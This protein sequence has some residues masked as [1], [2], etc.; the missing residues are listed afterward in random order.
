[1]K[2]GLNQRGSSVKTKKASSV[3]QDDDEESSLSGDDHPESHKRTTTS[4]RDARQAFNKELAAEQAALRLRSQKAMENNPNVYDYDAEYESFS[5]SVQAQAAAKDAESSALS[6]QA[7]EKRE[8]RYIQNLLQKAKERQY[9]R[10]IILERKIAREQAQEEKNNEY[11]GKEKFVTQSYK[12]K[13]Q[14]REDWIRTEESRQKQEEEEDVTKKDAGTAM[15]GFYGNLSRIG[16][17]EAKDTTRNNVHK[18]ISHVSKDMLA[19]PLSGTTSLGTLN[20]DPMVDN[21]VDYENV[22]EI[23]LEAELDNQKMRIERLQ[24]IFLARERYLKRKAER[25]S[26]ET[27]AGQQKQTVT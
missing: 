10:E 13:L 9:E 26:F 19:A 5:S 23:E 7:N 21:Q 20:R 16:T 8:S 24:K 3:F 18:E 22:E 1:M 2:F 17:G 25:E 15:M 12:K 11:M 14:E 4:S 27:N 6:K